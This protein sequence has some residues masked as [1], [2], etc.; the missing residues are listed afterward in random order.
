MRLQFSVFPSRST[1]SVATSVPAHMST[2]A[3]IV[4]VVASK[5]VRFTLLTSS[6]APQLLTLPFL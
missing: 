4:I 3:V 5:D 1:A 6:M 2:T